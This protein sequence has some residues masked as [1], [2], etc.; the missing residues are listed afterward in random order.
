MLRKFARPVSSYGRVA[1]QYQLQHELAA[2]IGE[3][4]ENEPAHGPVDREAAAP[5]VAPAAP[6]QRGLSVNGLQELV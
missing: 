2:E 6:E 3:H 4:E 1:V 5:A